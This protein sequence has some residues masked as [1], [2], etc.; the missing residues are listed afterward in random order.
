MLSVSTSNL[1]CRYKSFSPHTT[2]ICFSVLHHHVEETA[3]GVM[4]LLKVPAVGT[5]PESS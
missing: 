5:L 3:E 4:S 1:E 2:W